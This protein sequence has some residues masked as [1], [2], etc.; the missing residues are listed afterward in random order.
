MTPPLFPSLP[1]QAWSVHKRPTFATRIAAHASGRDVRLALFPDPLYEFELTFEGLDSL[2]DWPGLGTQSLQ[3]LFGLYLQCQGAFGTFVYVDPT[4]CSVVGQGVGT[5]DGATTSFP[6]TR[7][8]GGFVEPVSW[9]VSVARVTLSGVVL[10]GGWSLS[11]PNALV[12]E[13][14]PPAGAV[15]TADFS[16]GFLCRFLDDQCDFENV[17]QGL[18][19]VKSLKFRSVRT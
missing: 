13:A 11:P 6:L 18:W 16:Y 1:G 2:G 12:F 10:T 8:L 15:I 9:A 17:L 3:S 7:A 5:G 14:P 4:D 19:A